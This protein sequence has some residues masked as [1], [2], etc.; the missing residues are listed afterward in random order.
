MAL[1]VIT[2]EDLLA[3]RVSLV[4]ELQTVLKGND[5]IPQKWLP[6]KEIMK[7]YGVSSGTLYNWQTAGHLTFSKIGKTLY[8]DV[9]GLE[10][11]IESNQVKSF[12]SLSK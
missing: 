7:R 2:K 1:E 4:K 6:K 8:Y 10:A 9:E 5:P 11:L 3:F 12:Q